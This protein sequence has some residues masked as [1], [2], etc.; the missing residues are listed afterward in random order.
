MASPFETGSF[1]FS[2]DLDPPIHLGL[3]PELQAELAPERLAAVTGRTI[4]VATLGK[5]TVSA[6]RQAELKDAFRKFVASSSVSV[7]PQPLI[8]D[9]L[10]GAI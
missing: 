7:V 2:P 5:T 9:N 4:D 6:L 10:V 8:I 1:E 3:G